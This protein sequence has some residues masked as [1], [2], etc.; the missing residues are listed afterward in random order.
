[1]L[2]ERG[3]EMP[4]IVVS[5]HIGEDSAGTVMQAGAHDYLMKKNLARFGA[6][7]RRELREAELRRAYKQAEEALRKA[8]EELELKVAERTRALVQANLQLKKINRKLER[9][10]REDPLTGLMNRRM[11]LEI[12]EAEW[13]RWQRYRTPFS[14]MIIDG[15]DFKTIND[16]HGHLTGDNVLRLIASTITNSIRAVDRVGRYGGEEF[17]VILPDTG[18]EGAMTA[19]QNLL[20]SIRQARLRTDDLTIGITVSIGVAEISMDDENLDNLLR[21]ADRALYAAKRQGKDRVIVCTEGL[22]LRPKV[23]TAKAQV[24][25]HL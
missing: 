21:R 10:S 24:T 8:N 22:H 15:D 12:A 13:A 14:V 1:M 11:I 16:R 23:F 6:V 2:K 19:G 25:P 20:H 18:A 3:L 5:S 4:F 17:V 9:M 7:V